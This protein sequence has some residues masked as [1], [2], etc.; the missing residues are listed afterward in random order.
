MSHDLHTPLLCSGTI[1]LSLR[2]PLT[3]FSIFRRENRMLRK[4]SKRTLDSDR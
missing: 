2:V 3:M 1:M 4:M